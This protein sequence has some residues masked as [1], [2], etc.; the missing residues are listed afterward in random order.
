MHG[1]HRDYRA[2]VEGAVLH[3]LGRMARGGAAALVTE[4]YSPINTSTTPAGRT[5]RAM[6]TR[7]LVEIVWPEDPDDAPV[8]RPT[9]EGWAVLDAGRLARLRHPYQCSNCGLIGHDR[10]TCGTGQTV[11]YRLGY[12]NG[13]RNGYEA[14]RRPG[15]E[16]RGDASRLPLTSDPHVLHL[17][18]TYGVPQ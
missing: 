2:R 9:A 5:I 15:I 17:I 18:A 11:E 13:Y 7:G 10:R 4:G 14:G 1:N 6:F 16:R 12:K 3:H 8:F